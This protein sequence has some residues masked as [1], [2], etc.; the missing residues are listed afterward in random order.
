LDLI[1]RR[2]EDWPS[3]FH[4]TRRLAVR[5]R[6]VTRLNPEVLSEELPAMLQLGRGAFLWHTASRLV[7]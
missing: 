5:P 4:A 3:P 2:A 7:S 1:G 6:R